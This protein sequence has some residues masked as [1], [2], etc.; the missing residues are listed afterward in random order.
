MPKGIERTPL[1]NKFARKIMSFF[2]CD[3][4]KSLCYEIKG[5]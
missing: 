4:K 3:K 1:K 2:I 5:V